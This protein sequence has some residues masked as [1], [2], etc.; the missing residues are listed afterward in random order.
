MA[1][2]TKV[3]RIKATDDTKTPKKPAVSENIVEPKKNIFARIGG[4]FKGAWN[5]LKQVRWPTR[6]ATWGLT[7]AVII[8]S[9]F[10]VLLI[11][12]LDT[13]FNYVFQQIIA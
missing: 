5:E 8:F 2:K 6:K 7:L 9:L 11:L 13:L 3:T 4:Y 12:L 1:D 10:F